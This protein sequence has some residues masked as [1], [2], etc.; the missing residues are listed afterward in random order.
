MYVCMYVCMYESMRP[1]HY[2]YVHVMCT[3]IYV[4]YVCKQ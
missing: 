1:R 3:L 2:M 4:W